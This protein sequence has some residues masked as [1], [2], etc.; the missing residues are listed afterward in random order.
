[1]KLF[2]FYTE[3]TSGKALFKYLDK[4]KL[5]DALRLT[6][7]CNAKKLLFYFSNKSKATCLL[8]I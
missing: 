5:R 3:T 6:I 8:K 7:F 2:Y 4:H 1:M